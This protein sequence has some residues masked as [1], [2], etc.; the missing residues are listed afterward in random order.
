MTTSQC[1]P[2]WLV[3]LLACFLAVACY[4]PLSAFPPHPG[5]L[6]WVK[7]WW[8][9]VPVGNCLHL[10]QMSTWCVFIKSVNMFNLNCPLSISRI[11][12]AIFIRRVLLCLLVNSPDCCPKLFLK[13][14]FFYFLCWSGVK[15]G[16]SVM[17]LLESCSTHCSS[18]SSKPTC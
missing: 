3:F 6:L 18:W 4:C 12:H 9:H 16:F 5:S 17:P 8:Y 7:F 14:S 11:P 13:F 15:F 2:T 1:C 10:V